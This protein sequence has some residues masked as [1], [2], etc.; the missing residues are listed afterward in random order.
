MQRRVSFEPKPAI[1]PGYVAPVVRKA[2]DG[3]C[4]LVKLDW[5][6]V[7]LQKGLESSML[8]T[9]TSRRVKAQLPSLTAHRATLRCGGHPR[10]AALGP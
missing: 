3:E 6:F 9:L 5:G 2:D 4:E 7:L 8:G 1:F 10:P